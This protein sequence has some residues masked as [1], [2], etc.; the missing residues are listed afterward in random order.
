M[1]AAGGTGG[2]LFP[3]QALA[4]ELVGRGFRIHLMTEE[5][6]REYGNNFPAEVVHVV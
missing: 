4:E 6:V 2:H 3:A 5:R 1:L